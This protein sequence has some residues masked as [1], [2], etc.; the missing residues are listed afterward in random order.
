V[1][2]VVSTLEQLREMLRAKAAD[3]RAKGHEYVQL[4]KCWQRSPKNWDRA[5]VIPSKPALMGRIIGAT[6]RHPGEYLV[7]VK[8][9]E[10]EAWLKAHEGREVAT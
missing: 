6:G 3:S 8:L 7:D 2:A 10:L 5:R 4:I 9:D 1:G